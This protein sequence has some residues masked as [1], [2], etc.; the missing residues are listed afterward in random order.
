MPSAARAMTQPIVP[1][2]SSGRRPTL[3]RSRTAM[4]VKMTLVIPTERAWVIALEVLSPVSLR[5]VG[6]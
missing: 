4:I 1:T 5:I 2:I 6:A 3:S